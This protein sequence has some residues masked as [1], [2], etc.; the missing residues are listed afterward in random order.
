MFSKFDDEKNDSSF[1][2]IIFRAVMSNEFGT[3]GDLLDGHDNMP[4]MIPSVMVMTT[5]PIMLL[6][7]IM[8]TMIVMML[9]MV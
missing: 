4:A 2:C 3:H 5:R 6:I 8:L 9:D 1:V 7:M